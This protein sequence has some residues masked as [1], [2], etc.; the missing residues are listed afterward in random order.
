M[1]TSTTPMQQN[2]LPII[3]GTAHILAVDIIY[4]ADGGDANSKTQVKSEQNCSNRIFLQ[5]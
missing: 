5:F 1:T 4:T 3:G 2:G